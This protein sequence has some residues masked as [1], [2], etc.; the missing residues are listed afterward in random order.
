MVL[1]ESPIV[2]RRNLI[3]SHSATKIGSPKLPSIVPRSS[4]FGSP[5]SPRLRQFKLL[6]SSPQC[7]RRNSACFVDENSKPQHRVVPT[8]PELHDAWVNVI[9]PKLHPIDIVVLSTVS[10][11]GHSTAHNIM[12]HQGHVKWNGENLKDLDTLNHVSRNWTHL[13]MELDIWEEGVALKGLI[14]QAKDQAEI[15]DVSVSP[16][17]TPATPAVTAA[18]A[19]ALA[20]AMRAHATSTELAIT[21]SA[22]PS[23]TQ[24]TTVPM[25]RVALL[26]LVWCPLSNFDFVDA[27]VLEQFH[28]VGPKL[29]MEGRGSLEKMLMSCTRLEALTLSNCI[30]EGDDVKWLANALARLTRLS[31]LDLRC[32]YL[33]A[34]RAETLAPALA[35]LTNVTSLDL[36]VNAFGAEGMQHLAPSLAKMTRMKELILQYNYMGTEG[37]KAL[38]PSLAH[39]P[40]LTGLYLGEN[41][42]GAEGVQALIP[43]L[44]HMPLLTNV[45]IEVKSLGCEA[46]AGVRKMLPNVRDVDL[47]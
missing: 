35:Q 9:G 34:D 10:K 2:S 28:R 14:D 37:A 29:A 19:A 47:W 13:K 38:A 11:W 24:A 20:R 22:P 21:T 4:S 45:N 23:P 46:R 18:G 1:V 39:M 26:R 3:S 30:E 17:E 44:P 8:S 33:E 16:S 42:M 43:M 41:G 40:Q 15:V 7:P 31:H 12:N 5:L 25:C 36:G 27:S 32:N 6:H